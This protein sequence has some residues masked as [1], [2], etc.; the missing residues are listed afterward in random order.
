MDERKILFQGEM[1]LTA[2]GDSSTTGPWVKF[3]C[4]PEDLEQFKLLRARKGNK[5]A[6]T[7]LATVMVE[8]GDDEAAVTQHGGPPTPQPTPE[9][10]PKP[11]VWHPPHIGA[12]G[13]LAVR[14]CKSPDFREWVILQAPSYWLAEFGKGQ[15][16][17]M[18]K[19][20]ILQQ[21]GIT[22]DRFAV[23]SRKHLDVNADA[24]ALFH[25][26]IRIPY[27]DHLKE[28]GLA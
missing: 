9:P 19:Q 10:T 22:S 1:Q 27:L 24:A 12:L 26:R 14:Y 13:M 3:W 21:C 25:E 11:R 8:I 18:C 5:E 17:E 2:W 28:Q 4:H 20:Y 15:D 7:R 23:P 6:G 16:E